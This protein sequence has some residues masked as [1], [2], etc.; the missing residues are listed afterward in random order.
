MNK[1]R[2]MIRADG[3]ADIGAGHIMRCLS[4]GRAALDANVECLFVSAGDPYSDM[5]RRSGIDH[6]VLGT[7]YRDMEQEITDIC[8]LVDEF[9]PSILLVD[10]YFVTDTYLRTIGKHTRLAYIDD[11]CDKRY[12]VDT[13][14]NYH[15]DAK[16]LGTEKLYSTYDKR[17]K[18]LLGGQYA[19]LRKE[20]QGLKEIPIR[21]TVQDLLFSAGGADP[22]RMV[23]RFVRTLLKHDGSM[24]YRY[25]LVL[26]KYEPDIEEIMDLCDTYT[27]LIPHQ[28][29]I[30]MAKLMRKCDVAISASGTTLYELA[31]C[32]IPTITYILEDNQIMGSRFFEEERI[33]I[34]AGDV[35]RQGD[36]FDD[37]MKIICKVCDDYDLR[38]QMHRNALK[39][40]D[41]NG[42]VKLVDGLLVDGV[43]S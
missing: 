16:M 34:S 11:L 30:E 40:I 7:K 31:A 29:V 37:L 4:I 43:E 33:T 8:D 36:F 6:K 32:G 15:G 21:E 35:R 26:G 42:A 13:L 12:P 27:N 28:N 19:P 14:I 20:F 41:G 3:N 5:I 24:K 1:K 22:E 10:S 2:L 38:V 17:P 9:R 23:L 25:H 39:N 18:F